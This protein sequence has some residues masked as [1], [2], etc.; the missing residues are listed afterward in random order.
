MLG[1]LLFRNHSDEE[2][3]EDKEKNEQEWEKWLEAG[4]YEEGKNEDAD[5]IR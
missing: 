4:G 5:G 2:E 1:M 3:G